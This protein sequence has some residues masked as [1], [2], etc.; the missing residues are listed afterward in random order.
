MAAELLRYGKQFGLKIVA[1]N[2]VH[3]LLKDDAAAHDVL[4]CIQTGAKITDENRMRYSSPEFY[5]KTT[6]EMAALF[7]DV[8]G[9][10]ATTLEIAEKCDLKI[11]L[12]QNKFPAYTVPEGETRDGYLRRLCEEGLVR[13]FGE[14][15]QEPA[16]RERLRFELDV[17]G[18]TG[19]TSYFLIVWD[20]IDY[21]KRHGIPVGPGRGSAAGS[22]IAY[23]L[24]ITDIDPLRYGLFFERFLNPE[25]ISP[26]DIDID[27]CYNRR[28]EVIDYVR[29]KYG[30][31]C[32]AQIITFGT[33]GAKMAIRD[34][35][36]VMGM[37]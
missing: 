26:P 3:Y 31:R 22:L 36:R 11:E 7:R 6:E 8:P 21:A 37:S 25:R 10:L 29:K 33:L 4:L 5:L 20:F 13:R 27:F 23:V 17:L 24:G 15:A 2:D 19:F 34:V 14:R 9:A 32:V 35:G 12:G 30:E 28:G 16:L 18:K 1:T